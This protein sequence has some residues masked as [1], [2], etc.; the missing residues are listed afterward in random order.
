MFALLDDVVGL[1][2][3]R[4]VISQCAKSFKKTIN[5]NIFYAVAHKLIAYLCLVDDCEI[6]LSGK[7]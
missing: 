3:E 5:M 7:A 4:L 1:A 2:F 6:A